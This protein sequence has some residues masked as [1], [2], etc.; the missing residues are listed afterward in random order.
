MKKINVVIFGATGS[1]GDSFF[2][3]VKNN[4]EKFNIEGI[5]C[6]KNLRK[7]LKISNEFNVKKIGYNEKKIK[8]IKEYNLKNY[9]TYKDIE[10]FDKMI[11]S[12]TDVIVFAISGLKPINLFIKI[13]NANKIVGI[14]NKECII[15]LGSSLNKIIAK[16]TKLV[17]LD[18][19][20]N[21]IYHLLNNISF[22]YQSITITASGGPFLNLKY[23][24]LK[25]IK[26][27]QA[28]K[29]PIWKMGKK[30][31]IDSSTMM[32]KALEII[33]A[34]YLFNLNSSQIN[35]IIHPQ[36]IVHAIINHRNGASTALLYQPDMKVPISSLFFSFDN[37]SKKQ[38][39]L[40]LTDVSKL[41]FLEIDNKKFPAIN[42]AYQVLEIGGLAPNIFNY[43]NEILVQKFLNG[44]ISFIDIINYNYENLERALK[45]NKNIPIPSYNDIRSI[46]SW[47]DKNLYLGK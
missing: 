44:K 40:S 2:S 4:R 45:N 15:S 34:K 6:N 14:A 36:S 46:N 27:K 9:V 43:L 5:S 24:Q 41:E 22:D 37:Y 8:K 38:K 18:S 35:A 17:P 39:I 25:N 20:H 42:L 13:L 10:I 23:S 47:I 11:S 16:K 26:P 28:I 7:L 31:S 32:N 1:I 33:E 12:K 29:H 19:E 3:I 21:S 30:I